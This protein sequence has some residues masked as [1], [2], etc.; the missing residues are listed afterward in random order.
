MPATESEFGARL[1]DYVRRRVPSAADADDVVQEVLTHLWQG[2]APSA[3]A[4]PTAWLFTVARHAIADLHRRR[5]RRPAQALEDDAELGAV[6]APAPRELARCVRPLLDRLPAADRGLLERVDLGDESQTALAAEL[7][8]SVSG[9]KS[10]VQRA[11]AR[12]RHA[13]TECCRI[14]LDRRGLPTDDYE[15]RRPG[16]CDCS[17]S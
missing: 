3:P 12:L 16:S 13:V 8:L 11:R 1:R 5:R 14:E 4:A 10:R 17:R 6:K 7:R 9:L 15:C 2:R